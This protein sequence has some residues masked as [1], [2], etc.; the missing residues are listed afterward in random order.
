MMT[1]RSEKH[2]NVKRVNCMNKS[3]SEILLNVFSF[4]RKKHMPVW[5]DMRVNK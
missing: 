2:G 3:S 1:S 5:I 4:E